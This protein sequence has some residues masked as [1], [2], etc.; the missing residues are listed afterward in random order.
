M[1]S[2]IRSALQQSTISLHANKGAKSTQYGSG[3]IYLIKCGWCLDT[4]MDSMLALF[5]VYK[6]MRITT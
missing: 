1:R 3:P 6:L 2:Q 4:I 5:E